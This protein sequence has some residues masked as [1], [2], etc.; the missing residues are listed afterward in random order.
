M[1]REFKKPK[2]N[3]INSLFHIKNPYIWDNTKGLRVANLS[4]PKKQTLCD[5]L[6]MAPQVNKWSPLDSAHN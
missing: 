6:E 2:D 1:H 5:G 4:S 3:M